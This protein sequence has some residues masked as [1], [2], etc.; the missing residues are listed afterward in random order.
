MTQLLSKYALIDTKSSL[1]EN[2]I[3]AEGYA[4]ANSIAQCCYGETGIAVDIE[5][6]PVN[7]G[8]KYVNNQFHDTSDN[9]VEKIP[10]S[11]EKIAELES[12]INDL[13]IVLSDIIGG[14]S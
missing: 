7:I 8:Y 10:T 11:D 4:Q 1:V 13:T 5:Q 6:W 9:L 3:V 14:A 2:I 12:R